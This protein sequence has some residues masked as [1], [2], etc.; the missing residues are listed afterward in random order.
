MQ[1]FDP[2]IFLRRVCNIANL[3]LC[4]GYEAGECSLRSPECAGEWLA[5]RNVQGSSQSLW[6]IEFLAF[7]LRLKEVQCNS[8]CRMATSVS[9]YR[10]VSTLPHISAS[11]FTKSGIYAVGVRH[12]FVIG[13]S[14]AA[15]T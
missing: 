5:H 4:F 9:L 13:N 2:L 7:M 10:H 8:G 12:R 6:P 15:E 3:V 14:N 1:E 11:T